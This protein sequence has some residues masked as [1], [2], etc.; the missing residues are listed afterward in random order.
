[1][2]TETF[3]SYTHAEMRKYAHEH[4]QMQ[5]VY[6]FRAEGS[7]AEYEQRTGVV[8]ELQ[9]GAAQI[10]LSKRL[11]L[12]G[13]LSG[14]TSADEYFAFP[15]EGVEYAS[16]CSLVRYISTSLKATA[17][18][19]Q[20]IAEAKLEEQ[21][22]ENEELRNLN[23]VRRDVEEQLRDQVEDLRTETAKMQDA[24]TTTLAR[25]REANRVE[26]DRLKA[27]LETAKKK[28][29]KSKEP[30][31]DQAPWYREYLQKQAEL[32]QSMAATVAAT[33]EQTQQLTAMQLATRS[34]REKRSAPPKPTPHCVAS[35]R[36]VLCPDRVEM[37]T[38]E[39]RHFLCITRLSS[40]ALRGA[41]ENLTEWMAQ[42]TTQQEEE[43]NMRLGCR[44]MR[45][46]RDEIA[47]NE[48]VNIAA[49]HA[50][51]EAQGDPDLSGKCLE[52]DVYDIAAKAA[53][54]KASKPANS[55]RFALPKPRSTSTGRK[56]WWCG[57]DGHTAHTCKDHPT[58]API[59][60]EPRPEA[61][62]YRSKNGL[63]GF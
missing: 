36:P 14:K 28:S 1:M 7:D 44:L 57:R 5:I 51:L 9:G 56:C 33:A 34:E 30:A 22:A 31:V 49:V 32:T 42:A 4:G 43:R 19:E 15:M 50:A 18:R 53:G 6:W 54:R 17:D 13:V 23:T 58:G 24:T 59:P 41:F 45:A 8:H 11:S 60:T 21:R 25:E 63:G 27:D 38:F 55:D 29:A 20:R 52:K 12:P 3:T 39:L 16:P 62:E 10:I 47:R 40:T 26:L 46:V 35:W 48:H 37:W 61:V 2:P